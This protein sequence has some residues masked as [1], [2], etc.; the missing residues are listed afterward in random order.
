MRINRLVRASATDA[1]LKFDSIPRR[2]HSDPP[3]SGADA[4]VG[5]AIMSAGQVNVMEP[6]LTSVDGIAILFL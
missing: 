4:L 3:S 6:F 5:T 1:L 2:D